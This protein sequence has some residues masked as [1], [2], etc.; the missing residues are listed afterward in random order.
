MTREY[1][2]DAIIL[3]ETYPKMKQ[4]LA[5]IIQ[6]PDG[7]VL[8]SFHRHDYKEYIDAN[9]ETYMIDGG[10][11]YMRS[12][13]N[14]EPAKDVSI[15]SD[16]PFENRRTAKLWGTYGKNGDEPLRWVSVSEM[17][18]GHI[19][20]LLEPQM[21]VKPLIKEMLLEEVQYRN[22]LKTCDLEIIG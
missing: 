1:D 14:K 13:V 10:T 9:G 7:T 4:V 19:E 6:T 18:D 2:P 22:K 15:Y 11:E 5:S 21:Y 12:F 20:K 16:D 17:E 8:Q 3:P